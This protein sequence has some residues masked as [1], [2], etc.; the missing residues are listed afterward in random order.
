VK[1]LLI[2]FLIASALGA[3]ACGQEGPGED[4]GDSA[5]SPGL[6]ASLP[7]DAQARSLLGDPLYPPELPDE[8]RT[9]RQDQLDEALQQL[10]ADPSEAD[11]LIWVGRSP[12]GSRPTRMMPASTGT[13]GIGSSR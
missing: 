13:G 7:S 9:A 1:T 4:S 2:P 6:S 3:T 5:A 12:G 10:E 11:A 8:V